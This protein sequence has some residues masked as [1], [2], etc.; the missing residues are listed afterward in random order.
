M[1]QGVSLFAV[2]Y[3]KTYS[4]RPMKILITGAAGF[5]GSALTHKA[6]TDGHS[7][8]AYDKLTY[9]GHIANIQMLFGSNCEFVEGDI[10]NYE[11]LNRVFHE[12]R[13]DAIMNLAAESHVDNSISGPAPFIET[14]I[15]GTFWL[16]EAARN[17][18]SNL[19]SNKKNQFRFLHI[20]TDEV[21]GELDNNG[22]FSEST[23]YK[24]SSPYSATKAGSDHL[25]RAWHK[26][27][28]LPTIVTNCS[29]NYGPRQ[30]PEKLIPRI[31]TCALMGMPL[32]VYGQG[33]NIRDWIHV[34]DHVHGLML[35]LQKGVIGETYCFGGRA[36]K[37]NIET[38]K[39]I[40]K[41]LDELKPREDRKSYVDLITFVADRA[42]HD[43]RYAI[44]DTKAEN[45]LQFTRK[46]VS[47]EAG[48]KDTVQ[49]YLNNQDWL[50]TIQSRKK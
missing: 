17:Y 22:Y 23:S 10:A 11:L 42:G 20:S 9:A 1:R 36:E 4:L 5:I 25:V 43:W 38:V 41:I 13:I 46:Y 26:T 32:P 34:E 35:A 37:K 29:N 6:V 39:S 50:K 18:W 49:W 40:C 27:Y 15:V 33:Q 31:I 44:D 3:H 47:F 7:I 19:D 28:G 16:L 2:K 24:P 30:F 12:H 21:F 14:N 48:L 45:E 8:I